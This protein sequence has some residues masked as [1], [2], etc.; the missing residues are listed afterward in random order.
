MEASDTLTLGMF[1]TLAALIVGSI[2]NQHRE[3]NAMRAENTR[4]IERLGD[5]F[6]KRL[7]GLTKRLD[8]LGEALSGVRER[9]A[10]I[11]GHLRLEPPPRDEEP[12]EHSPD[13]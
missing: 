8:G 9:L 6:A 4:Q 5:Q 7:D 13:G 3:A 11:E 1:V 2:W 12:I 10:R